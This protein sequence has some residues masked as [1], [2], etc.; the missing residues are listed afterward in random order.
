LESLHRKVDA[1]KKE[2]L[3]ELIELQ[4][5]QEKITHDITASPKKG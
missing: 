5:K 2:K 1:L 3:G 4:K